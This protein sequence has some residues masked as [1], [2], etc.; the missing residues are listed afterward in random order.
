MSTPGG[1]I[2]SR[3]DR[4]IT[5]IFYTILLGMI[6]FPFYGSAN[7]SG[8]DSGIDSAGNC[9]HPHSRCASSACHFCFILVLFFSSSAGPEYGTTEAAWKGILGEAESLSDLH[10]KIRDHMA[11]DVPNQIRSWQKEAYH[12]VSL[13]LFLLSLNERDWHSLLSSLWWS[14]K[15]RKRWTIALKKLRNLGPRSSPKSTKRN[16]TITMPVKWSDRP[17]IRSEMRRATTLSLLNRSVIM[18]LERRFLCLFVCGSV[19]NGIIIHFS[20]IHVAYIFYRSASYRNAFSEPKK[21]CNRPRKSTMRLSRRSMHTTQNTWKTWPKCLTNASRWKHRGSFSLKKF[22]STF[23]KD[24]TLV[25]IR[26]ERRD[27]SLS[28]LIRSKKVFF[29]FAGK[30]SF[31]SRHRSVL[32]YTCPVGKSNM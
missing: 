9:S 19:S 27:L 12:K 1:I 17:P 23:T 24:W 25:K 22:F 18:H 31:F 13:L 15:R 29:F 14:L 20:V 30:V 21:R 7:A 11:E 26:G 16:W 2:I 5:F 3:V 32:S 4:P 10:T 28:L 8:R 6:F